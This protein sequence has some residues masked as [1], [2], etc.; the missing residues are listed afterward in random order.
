MASASDTSQTALT[1]WCAGSHWIQPQSYGYYEDS[2]NGYTHINTTATAAYSNPAA[3]YNG[4]V[5]W[6]D[7]H[8]CQSCHASGFGVSGAWPHYTAGM[9]FL[10]S[11]GGASLG[12][13]GA[14]LPEQ[15]GVCLRCHRNNGTDGIGY[16]Y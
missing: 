14:T 7:S 15:D 6:E 11:G 4:Q 1:K 5:A 9:R 12:S 10:E 3:T 8:Y 13:T 2:Q 16:D